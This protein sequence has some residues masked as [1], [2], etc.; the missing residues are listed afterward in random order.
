MN[1]L[2]T[3]TG[4]FIGRLIFEKIFLSAVWLLAVY[5]FLALLDLVQSTQGDNQLFYIFKVL[6]ISVPTMLYELSPMIF[7]I[8][9][10]VALAGFSRDLGFVALQAGGVSKFRITKIVVAYS[11][12]FALMV[13]IWG[14]CVVPVSEIAKSRIVSENRPIAT[15]SQIDDSSRWVRNGNH[16]IFFENISSQDSISG[17][18]IYE[19]D[20]S[21]QFDRYTKAGTATIQE[22]VDSIQLNQV[23]EFSVTDEGVKNRISDSLEYISLLDLNIL[24]AQESDPFQLRIDQLYLVIQFLQK[25][26]LKTEFFELAFWNRIVIP[27]SVIVMAL[28]AM[29]FTFRIRRGLSR[30]HFALIG[31]IFGLIYFAVQQSTGYVVILNGLVP[32]VGTFGTLLVFAIGAIIMLRRI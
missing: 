18:H 1:F 30:A 26:K 2:T 4:R 10:T 14:E 8:G 5:I 12:F 21:G 29:I 13:F 28:F 11:I 20:E 24:S 3:I 22:N 6:G 27:L 32:S 9:T 23:E 31:L 17:V 16:F 19:F 15:A 25:N 7:M